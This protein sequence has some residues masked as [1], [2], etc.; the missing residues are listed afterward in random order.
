MESKTWKEIQQ[1]TFTRWISQRLK[2][3]TVND[4]STDLADGVLLYALMGELSQ[5]DLGKYNP[6][7]RIQ[8]QKMENLQKVLNFIENEERI[9]LVNIGKLIIVH[10][11]VIQSVISGYD[12]LSIN[13][14]IVS[15]VLS[16]LAEV[17]RK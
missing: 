5:K 12:G 9:R 17:S 6:K 15:M 7:P 3:G 13:I 1:K 2:G 4:L 16:Y 14:G 8:V 10:F 11:H